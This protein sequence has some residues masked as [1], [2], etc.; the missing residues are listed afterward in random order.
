MTNTLPKFYFKSIVWGTFLIILGFYLFLRNNL[1]FNF[2]FGFLWN[3]WPL[4]LLSIGLKLITKDNMLRM[5]I[6]FTRGIIY[7]LVLIGIISSQNF[8]ERV[9]IGSFSNMQYQISN[10]IDHEEET[11]ENDSSDT[12]AMNLV[13]SE[14]GKKSVNLFDSVKYAKLELEAGAGVYKIAQN[15]KYLISVPEFDRTK[16]DINE[17]FDVIMSKDSS[18]FEFKYRIKGKL[19]NNSKIQSKFELSPKPIWSLDL[20]FGAGKLDL[21]LSQNKIKDINLEAGASSVNFKL[22]QI[23]TV[24]NINLSTGLASVSINIPRNTACFIK[25]DMALSERNFPNFIK[26]GDSF[27]TKN[28]DNAE[29]KLYINIEGGMSSY[30]INWY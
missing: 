22:G 18:N 26:S 11:D 3:L 16:G 5:L 4:I 23:D 27:K 24:S 25:T 15:S 30:S 13:I 28:F 9:H 7:A 10:N 19:N 21:D 6:A 12:L 2:D 17:E 1:N 20:E 29:K 14:N 8:W